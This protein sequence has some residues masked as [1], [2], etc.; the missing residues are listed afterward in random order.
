M[1][2]NPLYTALQAGYSYG[3][4]VQSTGAMQGTG[5]PARPSV[6]DI[7]NGNAAAL[8]GN[9]PYQIIQGTTD[10]LTAEAAAQAANTRANAIPGQTPSGSTSNDQGSSANVTDPG[11]S[12]QDAGNQATVGAPPGSPPGTINPDLITTVGGV[13]YITDPLNGGLV[14]LSTAPQGTGGYSLESIEVQELS[15]RAERTEQ[16]GLT[17]KIG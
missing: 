5:I 9:T 6:Q 7:I 4:I 10:S 8:T 17:Q 3:D 15:V 2:N 12:S 11:G 16:Q 1:A 13:Q 14:P